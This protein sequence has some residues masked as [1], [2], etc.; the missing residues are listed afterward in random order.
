MLVE[1]ELLRKELT[2]KEEET[3]PV[4]KIDNRLNEIRDIALVSFHMFCL[5]HRCTKSRYNCYYLFIPLS[6]LLQF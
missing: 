2:K 3:L 4:R 6:L 1:V 5:L